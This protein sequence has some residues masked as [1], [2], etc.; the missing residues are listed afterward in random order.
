LITLLQDF[1]PLAKND[2]KFDSVGMFGLGKTCNVS[3]LHFTSDGAGG[4]KNDLIR[5]VR[6][7]VTRV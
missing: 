4:L 6:L 7:I 5:L 2:G 1:N 3:F